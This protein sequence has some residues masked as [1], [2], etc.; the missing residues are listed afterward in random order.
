MAVFTTTTFNSTVLYTCNP[1]YQ[2]FGM[3]MRTCTESGVW[4]GGEPSCHS[5][6]I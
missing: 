2:L 4:T 6:Y 3:E 1:G 5:E